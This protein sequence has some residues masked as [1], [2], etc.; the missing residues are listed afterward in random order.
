MNATCR[1][2]GKGF[3]RNPTK[4][5]HFFCSAKCRAKHWNYISAKTEA[6]TMIERRLTALEK[7]I[8]DRESK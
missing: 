8:N 3:D 6:M 5:E 2:C 7:Y 1:Q 4:K